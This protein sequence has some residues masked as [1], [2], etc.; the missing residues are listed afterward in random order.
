MPTPRQRL[1]RV[2]MGRSAPREPKIAQRRRRYPLGKSM[3]CLEAPGALLAE[4]GS[5]SR[6]R[7]R[8]GSMAD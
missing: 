2:S 1:V 4:V 6:L 8:I 5:R 3:G 7:P